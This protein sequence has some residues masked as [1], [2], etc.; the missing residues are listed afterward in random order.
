LDLEDFLGER[1]ALAAGE[2]ERGALEAARLAVLVFR[3]LGVE[4]LLAGTAGAITFF[5]FDDFGFL[6]EAAGFFPFDF[7]GLRPFDDAEGLRP[8]DFFAA[9]FFVLVFLAGAGDLL[10][11]LRTF[12]SA[13]GLVFFSSAPA[14]RDAVGD[15]RKLC[16]F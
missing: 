1:D 6:L 9:G 13:F 14:L 11:L 15:N 8:A 5:P 10:R 3:G 7:E 2:E 16:L 4:G 12:F